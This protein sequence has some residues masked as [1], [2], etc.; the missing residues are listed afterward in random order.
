MQ[1]PEKRNAPG[2]E[3]FS[4]RVTTLALHM[5]QVSAAGCAPNRMLV[6][7]TTR[8]AAGTVTVGPKNLKM[9]LGRQI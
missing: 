7:Y 1:N 5:G 8:V 4:T 6:W 9:I 3:D 2:P